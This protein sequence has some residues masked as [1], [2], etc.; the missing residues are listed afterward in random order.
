M[1]INSRTGRFTQPD[2]IG[3]AGGLNLY[4]Y[5]DGDPINFSDPF[6]LCPK[7]AGGDGETEEYSDCP[8]GSSGYYAYRATQ[9]DSSIVSSISN[10]ILGWGA[11]CG[12]S[13]ECSAAA[14]ILTAF[15]GGKV[16]DGVVK[17]GQYLRIGVGR[18]DGRRWYRAA[19][20]MVPRRWNKGHIDFIDLGPLP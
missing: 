18:H 14:A 19:G 4:G 5:A 13:E 6:G 2:P 17:S 20:R 16:L 1:N 11:T 7:D 10:T 9:G 15:G 12:E 8:K 3:L